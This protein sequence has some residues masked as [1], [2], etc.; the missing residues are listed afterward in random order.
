M[1]LVFRGQARLQRSVHCVPAMTEIETPN[2]K[3]PSQ[4]KRALDAAW[5]AKRW[6]DRLDEIPVRWRM[7][8][9]AMKKG[10]AIADLA[11][12]G[13]NW[14][15]AEVYGEPPEEITEALDNVGATSLCAW[16]VAAVKSRD[17][18]WTSRALAVAHMK[19]LVAS[20]QESEAS[21]K[22][23][24]PVARRRSLTWSLQDAR[25][26][27]P[28]AAVDS[29]LD[30]RGC[31]C[32]PVAVEW[33]AEH[34]V[35]FWKDS[36]S[37]KWKWGGVK[38]TAEHWT[39]KHPKIWK[40]VYFTWEEEAPPFARMI[41]KVRKESETPKIPTPEAVRAQNE[42]DRLALLLPAEHIGRALAAE[43]HAQM[44]KTVKATVAFVA[45]SDGKR[46]DRPARSRIKESP[47]A[48]KE[49]LAKRQKRL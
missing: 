11:E 35:F 43:E 29:L 31:V 14:L 30:Y 25:E 27:D 5:A 18:A 38:H 36:L 21:A 15:D 1:A 45:K 41:G 22:H 44:Q 2:P 32:P 23:A 6:L 37:G 19:A 48:E 26:A 13:K 47:A 17:G 4:L 16:D 24:R 42:Q 20:G 9:E 8:R 3:P 28:D 7:E 49:A 10:K 33:I 40:H 46:K 39:V 34:E 12:K